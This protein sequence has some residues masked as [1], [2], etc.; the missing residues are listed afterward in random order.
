MRH[1]PCG[2]GSKVQR[3]QGDN[4]G[5]LVDAIPMSKQPYRKQLLK[6]KQKIQHVRY[7][8]NHVGLMEC[9]EI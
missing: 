3:T 5:K 4:T 2:A 7:S 9:R 6:Y 8:Y 1:A